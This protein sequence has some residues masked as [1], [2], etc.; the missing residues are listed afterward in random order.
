ML[1]RHSCP[2]L[3]STMTKPKPVLVGTDASCTA[4]TLQIHWKISLSASPSQSVSVVPWTSDS[5][6][7]TSNLLTHSL[8]LDGVDPTLDPLAPEAEKILTTIEEFGHYPNVCLFTTSRMHPEALGF[9][10]VQVSTISGD[11][12]QGAFH[13]LCHPGKSPTIDDLIARLDPHPLST[14]L[15]ST[16]RE[17]NWDESALLEEWDS[18]MSVLEAHFH[19]SLRD[20]VESSFCSPTIQSLGTTAREVLK[21][22][23]AFPW[24]VEECRLGGAL[25]G[26][27]GLGWQ[28]TYFA[29]SPFSIAKAGL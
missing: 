22:I 8:L 12:A 1:E 20:V 19:Q 24:D 17:N 25:P 27:T 29:S 3:S 6:G 14:D 11:V 5:F 18:K 4:M 28:S 13:G 10:R 23:T 16:V 15:L 9:Y 26:L 2:L 21:A 7:H